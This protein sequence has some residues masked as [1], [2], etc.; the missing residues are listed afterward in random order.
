VKG[1]GRRD[2]IVSDAVRLSVGETIVFVKP[3]GVQVY[4]LVYVSG[5]FAFST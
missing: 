1:E 4:V 5:I 2:D 3:S